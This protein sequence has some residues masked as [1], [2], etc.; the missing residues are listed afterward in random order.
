MIFTYKIV[1]N[2]TRKPRWKRKEKEERKVIFERD[3]VITEFT[4]CYPTQTSSIEIC[5][6]F[7]FWEEAI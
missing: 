2:S 7:L 5:T 3:I 1:N 6:P 4:L